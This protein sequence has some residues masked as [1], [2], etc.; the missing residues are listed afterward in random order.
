MSNIHLSTSNFNFHSSTLLAR[1]SP[2]I[3]DF[4]CYHVFKMA[5]SPQ[6]AYTAASL[7]G[8]LALA[9]FCPRSERSLLGI[10][11]LYLGYKVAHYFL[12]HRKTPIS[13]SPSN[14]TLT[15]TK[16]APESQ[17]APPNISAAPKSTTPPA[18]KPSAVPKL[19]PSASQSALNSD[20]APKPAAAP[21]STSAAPKQS[22][23]AKPAAPSISR[24]PAS[25]NLS[26]LV[27]SLPKPAPKPQ[28][29]T[30]SSAPLAA[31]SQL[32][33]APLR[34]IPSVKAITERFDALAHK[35]TLTFDG[36]I[37]V[38]PSCPLQ[39]VEQEIEKKEGFKKV[40]LDH[41][42]RRCWN[43]PEIVKESADLVK[44]AAAQLAV[45]YYEL[46][47]ATKNLK[48]KDKLQAMAH[49]L[50][51]DKRFSERFFPFNTKTVLHIY[52]FVRGLHYMLHCPSLIHNEVGKDK[53]LRFWTD[54]K[55]A[56]ILPFNQPD[57][58]QHACK[59]T[60]N[61]VIEIFAPLKPY[62]SDEIQA[63]LVQ[64]IQGQ[65]FDITP[66]KGSNQGNSEKK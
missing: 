59:E 2:I 10:S 27:S 22:S 39:V 49:L 4:C 7:G 47:E 38:E 9:V 24:I 66:R 26:E 41:K 52:R 61:K 30:S 11:L 57:T 19:Q 55:D 23:A 51:N 60:Y 33:Q 17:P 34:K 32:P 42:M 46:I 20:R 48:G 1:I 16:S 15:F 50:M 8:V 54:L 21:S 43:F 62:L 12:R 25:Q 45:L 35:F 56:D 65:P 40:E 3:A 31:Q 37:N 18:T 58:P 14:T 64:D 63:W 44:D 53:K 29:A 6:K 28:P 36:P 13:R 5:L